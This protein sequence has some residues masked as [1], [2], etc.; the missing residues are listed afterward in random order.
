MEKV[1]NY[2][3]MYCCL[4]V[5]NN[6]HFSFINSLTE[7]EFNELS[8]DNILVFEKCKKAMIKNGIISEKDIMQSLKDAIE[9]K[10]IN[11][12]KYPPIY[13]AGLTNDNDFE[14]F[15]S[16]KASI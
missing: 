1:K 16:K 2:L 7:K 13:V 15:F 14:E 4:P 6:F 10:N 8:K 5:H 3:P 12:C 9:N 11:E